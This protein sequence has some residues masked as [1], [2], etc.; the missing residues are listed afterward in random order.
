M[1]DATD[2]HGHALHYGGADNPYE[3]IKVIEHYGLGFCLGNA[4][5]YILRSPFKGTRLEGLRKAR[6]YMDREIQRISVDDE[7]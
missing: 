2:T 4:I 1:A 5:K 7:P 6:W 3:A